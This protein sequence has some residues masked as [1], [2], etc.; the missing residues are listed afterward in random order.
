[1][2]AEETLNKEKQVNLATPCRPDQELVLEE[3]PGEDESFYL[4]KLQK[5]INEMMQ[6]TNQISQ[7]QTNNQLIEKLSML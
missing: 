7:D 1:M 2:T 3:T 4:A 5:T 6:F